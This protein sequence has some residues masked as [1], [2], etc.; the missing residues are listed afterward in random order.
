V[1]VT[2]RRAL[3]VIL[4]VIILLIIWCIVHDDLLLRLIVIL[5][6][7]TITSFFEVQQRINNIE[8]TRTARHAMMQYGKYF[9]QRVEIINNS[10]LTV[11][12]LEIEDQSDLPGSLGSRVFEIIPRKQTANYSWRTLLSKRGIFDLGPTYLR[13][14]DDF[15]FYKFEKLFSA[16]QSVMVLPAVE[17]ITNFPIAGGSQRNGIIAK[18]PSR[19]VTPQAAGVREFSAGDDL[20]HIHWP[21]SIKKNTLMVKEFDQDLAKSYWI[22]L[23]SDRDVHYTLTENV[24]ISRGVNLNNLGSLGREVKL[25]GNTFEYAISIVASIS[26]Y[27]YDKSTPYGFFSSAQTPISF[28]PDKND[29]HFTKIMQALAIL[30]PEGKVSIADLVA[31]YSNHIPSNSTAIIISP[32]IDQQ[33][34][35]INDLMNAKKIECIFIFIDASTFGGPSQNEDVIKTLKTTRSTKYFIECGQSIG[36]TLSNEN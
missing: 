8:I 29:R 34:F 31:T 1:H 17:Q 32:R 33:M 27:F 5:S 35:L 12:K 19:S 15:S 14:N 9:D 23:D 16:T 20:N 6:L 3:F 26:K 7:I 25:P 36:K 13:I 11:R 10:N 18:R 22:L 4:L 28:A 30:Q 21:Y 24:T 2:I